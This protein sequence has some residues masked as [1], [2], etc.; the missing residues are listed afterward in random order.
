MHGVLLSCFAVQ[1]CF[2]LGHRDSFTSQYLSCQVSSERGF[3]RIETFEHIGL[4]VPTHCSPFPSHRRALPAETG[5]LILEKLRCGKP[6]SGSGRIVAISDR[7][8]LFGDF[9]M[10]FPKAGHGNDRVWKAWKA[11]KP[12][13]HPS[14]TLWKSLRDCHIPTASTAGIFQSAKTRETESKAFRPQ[15]GCNGGPWSKV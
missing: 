1:S 7:W 15:G 13:F 2:H 6:R 10:R 4:P 14:H 11:K 8:S 3:F 9:G 5:T 12:A